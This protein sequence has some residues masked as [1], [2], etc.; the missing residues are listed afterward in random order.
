MARTED[1]ER[2]TDLGREL[3]DEAIALV[4]AELAFARAEFGATLG[5]VRRIALLGVAVLGLLV[6]FGFFALGTLAEGLG[7]LFFGTR[8]WIAWL[9]LT[10]VF[11]VGAAFCGL[12][13]YRTVRSTI[14]EARSAVEA[15]KEDIAWVQGLTRRSK[16][17]S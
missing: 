8:E 2:L 16:R 6:L 9:I 10:G 15:I 5:R 11:L 1:A 12:A 14:G 7:H 3:A 4:K 17:E 13:A